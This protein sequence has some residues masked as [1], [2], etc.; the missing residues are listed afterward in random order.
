[1]I[2]N[3]TITI[4]IVINNQVIGRTRICSSFMTCL[5]ATL[6]FNIVRAFTLDALHSDIIEIT[7]CYHYL[8]LLVWTSFIAT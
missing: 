3:D 4:V 2:D 8:A 5:L 7:A 1:M 6:I